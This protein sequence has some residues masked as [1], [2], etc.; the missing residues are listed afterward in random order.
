M[1]CRRY[2]FYDLHVQVYSNAA[3][4]NS[5]HSLTAPSV[6]IHNQKFNKK[7]PNIIVIKYLHQE[8]SKCIRGGRTP[9]ALK[10][11]CPL[12]F[13]HLF[14]TLSIYW[15]CQILLFK[16]EW[17]YDACRVD[18]TYLLSQ[19]SYHRKVGAHLLQ[20]IRINIK[21]WSNAAVIGHRQWLAVDC[22]ANVLHI[23][24]HLIHA[25]RY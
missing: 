9:Y 12:L 17:I 10:L 14:L 13:L 18:S 8:A 7:L 23:F 6:N 2:S 16:Y 24:S 3:F 11:Q 4:Q 22:A 25:V 5:V 20:E 15:C 19:F 1:T 21:R